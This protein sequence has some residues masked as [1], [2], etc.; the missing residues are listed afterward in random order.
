MIC[1]LDQ[2]NMH[3]ATIEEK[4]GYSFQNKEFLRLAFI[5][6]SFANENQSF[7]ENHNERLEF[8]GDAILGMMVSDFLYKELPD[9]PEGKLSYL[10]SLL[11]E[12]KSCAGYIKKLEIAPFLL[13]GKGEAMNKGKGRQSVLAD[14]FEAVVGAIYLDG[15]VE[16]VQQFFFGHF[17]EE[18]LTAIRKPCRNWK[19]ELQDFCQKTYHEPPLYRVVSQE[20]PDH[21][22]V[23]YVV[24]KV[25][26]KELGRGEGS[27]KKEAEQMAAQNVITILGL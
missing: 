4:I 22:K 20:G 13:L 8:L 14:L 25:K 27:S 2:L 16:H 1:L 26:G 21:L 24:V 5:H 12:S 19:A 23:F 6:R 18:I 7:I 9:F 17:R 11:V 10:R 15:G 3:L